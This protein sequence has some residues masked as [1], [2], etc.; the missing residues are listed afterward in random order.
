MLTFKCLSMASAAPACAARVSQ[1]MQ[2]AVDGWR[3]EQLEQS[4]DFYLVL[5]WAVSYVQQHH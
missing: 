2:Q 1:Q 5:V 3:K 4:F